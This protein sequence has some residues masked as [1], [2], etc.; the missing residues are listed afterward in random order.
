MSE[1]GLAS[2]LRAYPSYF[3]GFIAHPRYSANTYQSPATL[4]LLNTIM[5]EN[6]LSMRLP[7]LHVFTVRI[8]SERK[9]LGAL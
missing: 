7:Y 5:Q 8:S 2:Q 4:R 3:G 1:R 9:E 6:A